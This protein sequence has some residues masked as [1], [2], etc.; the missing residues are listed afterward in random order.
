MRLN[1]QTIREFRLVSSFIVTGGYVQIQKRL[2][3][4]EAICGEIRYQLYCVFAVSR[5]PPRLDVGLLVVMI[6]L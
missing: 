5:L 3:V 6:W 4:V 1:S 2:D